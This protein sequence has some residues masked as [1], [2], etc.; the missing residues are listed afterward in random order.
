V[1]LL[2]E[3]GRAPSVPATDEVSVEKPLSRSRRSPVVSRRW[4]K[5]EEAA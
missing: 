4:W 1:V 2:E 5:L 3:P